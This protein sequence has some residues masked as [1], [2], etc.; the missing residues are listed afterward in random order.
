[1]LKRNFKKHFNEN[2]TVKELEV[3]K[4]LREDAKL[5]QQKKD[6]TNPSR[7]IGQKKDR[8]NWEIY[9]KTPYPKEKYHWRNLFRQLGRN[10]GK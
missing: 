2:H 4:Q 7:T 10:H 6:N 5:I 9:R 8:K 3:K 1:M